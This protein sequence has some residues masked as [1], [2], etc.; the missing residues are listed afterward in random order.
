MKQLEL[1]S[2]NFISV[3]CEVKEIFPSNV[4]KQLAT[5]L[6]TPSSSSVL[7]KMNFVEATFLG[8]HFCSLTPSLCHGTLGC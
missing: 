7:L 2:R 1:S 3:G 4:T 6:R 5:L 8:R